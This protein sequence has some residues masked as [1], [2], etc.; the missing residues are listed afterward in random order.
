MKDERA[1]RSKPPDD[2]VRVEL[3]VP[4]HDVDPLM[5]AWHGHYYKYFEIGR[6]ALQRKHRVDAPDLRE[7]GYHWYVIETRARHVAPMRY[8][9]RFQ[10]SAW[11]F[12]TTPRIGIAYEITNLASGRRAARGVTVLVTTRPD[13]EMLWETPREILERIGG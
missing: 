11:F 10:V 2:A 3:E 7:M 8:G 13:G 5:V 9:D 4:F 6:Q 1:L 12:E